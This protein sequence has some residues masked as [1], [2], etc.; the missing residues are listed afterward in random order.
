MKLRHSIWLLVLTPA[1]GFAQGKAPRI[2]IPAPV[3]KV[4]LVSLSI[5]SFKPIVD[6]LEGIVDAIP[7]GQVTTLAGSSSGQQDGQGAAAKFMEPT[8]VCTDAEGNVYVADSYNHLIRKITPSGL[9]STIAGTGVR[10]RDNGT[11]SEASFDTPFGVMVDQNGNVFVAD[12]GN[13]QIRKITPG[14]LVSVYA[15]NLIGRAGAEDGAA[16]TERLTLPESMVFDEL[17]NMYVA[18]TENHSIRKISPGIEVTTFSGY[19]GVKGDAEGQGAIARYEKPVAI[20][21]DPRNGDFYV[22]DYINNK[23]RRISA[24]GLMTTYTGTGEQSSINGPRLTAAFDH[25]TGLTIDNKGNVYVSDDNN[26]IRRISAVTGLVSTIAGDGNQGNSDGLRWNASFYQPIGLAFDLVGNLY[27]ADE[28]NHRIRKITLSGGF[29]IDKLLPAGLI[30][31]PTNGEISGTPTEYWPETLYTITAY[32]EFGEGSA[33]VTISVVDPALTFP[34]L[35]EKQQCDPDFESGA[36]AFVPITYTFSNPLVASYVNGKIH[37]LNAG[38]TIITATNGYESKSQTLIV[39]PSEVLT[40]SISSSQSNPSCPGTKI[41]FTANV[42]SNAEPGAIYEWY[43]NEI[44]SGQTGM[45]FTSNSFNN[46]DLVYCIVTGGG[47]CYFEAT[48]Q[49]NTLKT[50]FLNANIC[51]ANIP[52]AFSPNGDGI[53]DTWRIPMLI[54]YPKSK[55]SIYSRSG[56]KIFESIGYELPWNGSHDG[57]P[58]PAG[59]YYYVILLNQESRKMSGSVAILK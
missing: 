28:H 36:T 47:S 39:S 12:A 7:Y 54:G 55:M 22:A 46:G 27:V 4:Y 34:P 13:N 44:K 16:G 15:G 19:L 6:P 17:G 45:T 18:D 21:R 20:A 59:V 40:I 1:L 53:N 52:T 2:T 58:L 38:T 37:I 41:T 10:G 24:N 25:P 11:S 33:E 35:A 8:G 5:S 29:S 50:D 14:G 57:K 56:V 51:N 31:D 23:V 3:N 42:S 48:K 49:S 30:F 9:V 26:L 32:N 43:V